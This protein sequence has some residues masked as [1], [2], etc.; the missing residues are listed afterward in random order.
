MFTP[1]RISPVCPLK[2]NRR[3]QRFWFWLR[4]VQFDSAMLCTPRSLTPRYDAHCKSLT[5]LWNAHHGAW[6]CSMMHTAE[7]DSTMWCTPQSFFEK[8]GSL[9]SVEGCTQRSLTTR[10]ASRRGVRP[11]WKCPF[12]SFQIHNVFQLCFIKKRLKYK[13]ENTKNGHVWA[14]RTLRY[15]SHRGV[16]STTESN[17]ILQIQNQILC[18]PLV[19]FKGTSGEIVLGVNTSIM[20]EKI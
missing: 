17:C 5:P 14:Y 10:C 19:A 18:E 12:L 9:D 4:G 8:F 6:L 1:I 11:L 20:K 3:S 7:L 2:G 16:L 15:A 13:Y